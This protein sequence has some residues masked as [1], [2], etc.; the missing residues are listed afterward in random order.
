MKLKKKLLDLTLTSLLF[1]GAAFAAPVETDAANDPFVAD[2]ST[3]DTGKKKAKS[4][5]LQPVGRYVMDLP[6][7]GLVWAVEDPNLTAPALSVQ[8][9]S[10]V[11]L[12]NGAIVKPVQFHGYT[13][14]PSFIKK[15]E[16]TVYRGRDTDLVTPLAT[17]DLPVGATTDYTWDG[18]LPDGLNLRPGDE[19]IYVTRAYGADGAFDETLSQRL[20]LVTP[21]DYER[22]ALGVRDEMQRRLGESLGNDQ[23][24]NLAIENE[25]YGQNGLR[26][27]NIP[28]YGSRVRL[29]GRGLV[30][31]AKLTINGQSVMVD[32]ERKFVAE[33]LEPI[34]DHRYEVTFEAPDTQPVTQD[35]DV[36]VTGQYTFL[37]AMAD[38]TLSK[39]SVSGSVEPQAGNPQFD[40]GFLGEGRLAFY[41]KKKIQ[42]KYLVT[43]QADTRQ[44]PLDHTFTDFLKADPRDVFRRLD[45]DAYYPIYGDDSTTYRDVDTQGRFYVRTDWDQNQA[46]WGNFNT[47]M[48][49]TEYG[50]YNRS[51]YGAA[52]SWR[53]RKTTSLGHPSSEAKVFGSQAQSA[54][55]HSEF[56]GTGGS[57]Y[58]LRHTDVLPGSDKLVLEVRDHTTGRTEARVELARGADYEMDDLQGR[59]ILSRPLSQ[60]TRENVHT[61]TRDTPIDGYDQILL[62][63]Y[64][65]VPVGFDPANAS[66]G[67][68]GKHW[69]GDHV[70]VGGTYVDESRSGENYTLKAADVTLQAGRGTYLKLE[71]SHTESTAAPIFFSDN[72]GLSFFERNNVVGARSGNARSIEARANLKELGWTQRDW[73]TGAWWRDVDA[74]FSTSH[75]DD[76]R[77]IHE[78]GAEVLGDIT[79]RF[80]I[81][82]RYS[83]AERGTEA[84]EQAQVTT[85]WR[86]TDTVRI[87]SELRRVQETRETGNTDALLGALSYTQRI[88]SNLDV[89]T[90]GQLTL[91]DDGGRYAKNNLL[92]VGSKYQFGDLS[93]IGAEV[94]GGSRGHGAQVNGEYRLTPDHTLYGAYNYTTDTTPR[95]SLFNRQLDS[96]WTLGQRWRLNNQTNLY[97][98]SQFLKDRTTDGS[99]ISHSLGA[100]FYPGEGWT[101]GFALMEGRL[102]TPNGRVNRHAYSASAGQTDERMQ[103]SS[104]L[105]YREDRGAERRT[106]WVNTN[107]VTYKVNEDWRLAARINYA[108]T[109]D[110]INAAASA[111]LVESNVGFAWRPHDNTRWAAFGKYTYLYDLASL[112]Q[113]GADDKYDQRSHVLA[114]EG[115]TQLTSRWEL[116]GKLSSR[117]GQYRLGR[118]TGPWLNSHADFAAAQLRYRITG[119]WEALAE[120]RM[121]KV[122]EGGI[123]R[124]W[125]VGLD[126]QLGENFKLGVGYNFTHFSDDLT[127][128]RYDNKG[129]FLNLTGYY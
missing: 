59:V 20:Q 101:T 111:K 22:G 69:F 57:L 88:G 51:L 13:N 124:G 31:N 99:G 65:Y 116:A 92:T 68:R 9:A 38:M 105:E 86:L 1:S 120:H 49:G 48:T 70:G 81:Y 39:N 37:V 32:R 56:L 80:N 26:L 117:W 118:G 61:I 93:N 96:G 40:P 8:A 6:N 104:K 77:G 36:K 53:S 5:G 50:Q 112:G 45:P 78:Y 27:Q 114:F 16:V 71:Q 21:A 43:A 18:H 17:F 85:D 15:L 28:V 122:K 90:I 66:T 35:I 82:S 127:D 79:E 3:D 29:N 95:D 67:L 25:V 106:Q 73:S 91:N 100:D 110:L 83:R 98:E 115:I 119:K 4:P 126:R 34:G 107:R 102:D 123:R 19:L 46:L 10:M 64:E 47:G 75:F 23:A 74:G 54:P 62:A 41:L 84:L 72:G 89:Y 58:Y 12:D 103:W 94:S 11:P 60:I 44:S 55:G 125:L 42:G 108:D 97:N 2:T 7:G 33:F 87:G 129:W 24:Q 14:Y 76:A 128:L 109:K 121:L 30:P 63:D 113:E 52:L